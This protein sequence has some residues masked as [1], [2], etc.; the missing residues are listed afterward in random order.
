MRS[1]TLFAPLPLIAPAAARPS[2]EV[3]QPEAE[4]LVDDAGHIHDIEN[5]VDSV[6]RACWPSTHESVKAGLIA[7][8]CGSQLSSTPALRGWIR[9]HFFDE[10]VK[11]YSKS[12]RR[13]PVYWELS[14]TSHSYSIWLYYHTLT[15]DTLFRM[16]M[17]VISPKLQFEESKLATL[18]ADAGVDP[19]QSQRKELEEQ[20]SFV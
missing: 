17:E 15:G 12:R 3:S 11:R 8:L 16:V 2:E 19:T 18:R 10:H 5:A 4:I 14:T 13:A 6:L 9:K 20:E 7:A 1:E